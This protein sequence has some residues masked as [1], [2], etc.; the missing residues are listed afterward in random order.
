[1]I[2]S[3][4]P[5]TM[6]SFSGFLWVVIFPLPL[7]AIFLFVLTSSF[8][9]WS[10]LL[11]SVSRLLPMVDLIDLTDLSKLNPSNEGCLG[12]CLDSSRTWRNLLFFFDPWCPLTAVP[13]W[14]PWRPCPWWFEFVVSPWWWWCWW[15]WEKSK[16]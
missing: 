2:S 7:N 5:V 14:L 11:I 6:V 3:T 4:T 9:I 10:I 8:N 1:M 16:R 12:V 15:W 13:W